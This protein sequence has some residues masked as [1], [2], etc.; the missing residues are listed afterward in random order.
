MSTSN[1]ASEMRTI[2]SLLLLAFVTSFFAAGTASAAHVTADLIAGDSPVPGKPIT[3]ALRLHVEKEWH[4][5]WK[6]PGDA[7]LP[8][9]IA[10][11]LPEGFTAGPIIW[12]HPYRY[13][14]PPEVTYGYEDAVVLPVE[15]TPPSS[16]NGQRVTLRAKASWLVCRELCVSEHQD[17]TLTLASIR[18]DAPVDTQARQAIAQALSRAPRTPSGLAV[19]AHRAGDVYLLRITSA[20]HATHLPASAYFFPAEGEVI[21]HSAEQNPALADDALLLRLPVSPYASGRAAH[22]RGVLVSGDGREGP[23]PTMNVEIDVPVTNDE[24]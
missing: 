13:G 20:D 4:V 1:R 10:W 14:K 22:L 6:N 7:G 3:V 2:R 17:V 11:D 12:P 5:Y 18:D 9:S 15:I 23:E 21:D 8:V 19:S 24:N 16:W